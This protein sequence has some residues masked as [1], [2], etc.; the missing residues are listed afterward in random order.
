MVQVR[1]LIP[2]A[3][4]ERLDRLA[5]RVPVVAGRSAAHVRGALAREAVLA[6]VEALEADPAR[7]VRPKDKETR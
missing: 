5:E 7:L 3:V 1:V 4:A 6:G 2:E